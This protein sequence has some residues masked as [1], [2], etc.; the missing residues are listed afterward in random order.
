M[1]FEKDETAVMGPE[2]LSKENQIKFFFRF[3][4]AVFKTPE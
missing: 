1:L 3:N 4:L 2:G